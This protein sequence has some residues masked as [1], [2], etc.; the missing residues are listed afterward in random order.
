[1]TSIRKMDQK[2]SAQEELDSSK[3]NKNP[4]LKKK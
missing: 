1:M 4:N 3:V 2:V